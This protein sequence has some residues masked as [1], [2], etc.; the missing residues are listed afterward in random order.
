LAALDRATWSTDNSP[1]PLWGDSV[2]FYSSDPMEDVIVADSDDVPVGYVKLRPPTVPR[3]DDGLSISGIAVRPDHQRQ[4]LGG[5]L[6]EEAIDEARGR[7]TRRLIL[8]VLGTN[9][10]AI[11]L[12]ESHGFAVD[13]VHRRAF[14]LDQ[15][16]VDDVVMT[17]TVDRG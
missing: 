2:D 17:R 10:A 5:R 11:R 9:A 14:W 16:P 13:T 8:H 6:L 3:S 7:G 12:Y 4:G 1:V 15:P